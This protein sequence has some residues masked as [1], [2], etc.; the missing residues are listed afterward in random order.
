ME[1]YHTYV[2]A[3]VCSRRPVV[4]S[5][6]L[7]LCYCHNVSL[8][9]C[10]PVGRHVVLKESHPVL[11]RVVHPLF[12]QADQGQEPENSLFPVGIN[13]KLFQ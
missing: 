12:T 6:S 1:T 4:M 3:D 2:T 8:K 9:W 13:M 11:K 5:V 10:D 7:Q